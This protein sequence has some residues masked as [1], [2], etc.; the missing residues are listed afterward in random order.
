MHLF[1]KLLLSAGVIDKRSRFS[2]N[3]DFALSVPKGLREVGSGFKPEPYPHFRSSFMPKALRLPAQGCEAL[4]ATLGWKADLFFNPERVAP[5]SVEANRLTYGRNPF[6]VRGNRYSVTQGSSQSFAT[7]GWKAQ[8]L[9]CKKNV[10]KEPGFN[11]C[12]SGTVSF[13]TIALS[14]FVTLGTIAPPLQAEES[15]TTPA[16]PARLPQDHEYQKTLRTFMASLKEA[17]FDHDVTG[18]VTVPSTP[19]DL[20]TLYSVWLLS[21]NNQP[22]VGSKRGYPS[23]SSPARLFVL[24]SIEGG[25]KIMQVPVWSPPMSWLANWDYPGNPYHGSRAIKLRAF[26]HLCID[27][28]ML[29]HQIETEPEKGGNRPDWFS[30]RLIMYA[31][32]WQGIRDVLPKKVRAAY[33]TGLRKMGRRLLDWGIKRE[34]CNMDAISFP[35]LVLTSNALNDSAFTKQAKAFVDGLL[36]DPTFFHPTGYFVDQRGIDLNFEGMAGFSLIWAELASGWPSLGEAVEKWY[37]LRSHLILS[38]PKRDG[39]KEED[40]VSLSPC[41]FNS[42]IGGD[43]WPAQWDWVFREYG[44]AMVTNEAA[45]L[46]QLPTIEEMKGSYNSLAGKLNLQIGQNPRVRDKNGKHRHLANDEIKSR[47]WLFRMWPSWNFPIQINF[48]HDNYRKGTY[49]RRAQLQ[50]KKSPLLLSPFQRG[51]TFIRSFGDTFTVARAEGFAAIIHTGPVGRNDPNSGNFQ[52]TGPLGFGGGQLS[53]F[54]TPKTGSLIL[55]RRRGQH[56]EKNFDILE[57]WRIWPIHAVSGTKKDG[58][59]FTSA[60]IIKPEVEAKSKRKESKVVVRGDIPRASL[61]QGKVLEGRINYEREFKVGKDSVSIRTHIRST[62]QDTIAE[63]YETIPVMTRETQ[64]KEATKIEFVVE[65]KPVLATA[66]WHTN[67]K[68]IVLTRFG[69]S[70]RIEFDTPQRVKLSPKEWSDTYM[71]RVACRNI[72]IDLLKSE[73]P[74]VMRQAEASYKITSANP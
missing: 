7:L 27:M 26:V 74:K 63:L 50:E 71:T 42:R 15:A 21:L 56:W 49:A 57:D 23:V 41:Q 65:G 1:R 13:L 37:R 12:P 38:Q 62:G 16:T 61:G 6:G 43:V 34:E 60:R 72:M 2:R 73:G 36:A 18:P 55:G 32:T 47:P 66:D 29:D 11:L 44:G 33:E 64:A 52:F 35:G 8:H 70:V 69:G 48:T 9:R 68:S 58:K 30:P 22:I 28:M 67:V 17:D 25:E 10:G 24:S 3:Y 14:F 31:Y 5:I 39:D 46:T 40:K 20:D 45:H 4:R 54:W 51:E 53:A 19:D 59:V